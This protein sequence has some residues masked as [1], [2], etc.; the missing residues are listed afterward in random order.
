MIRIILTDICYLLKK[1]WL[2]FIVLVLSIACSFLVFSMMTGVINYE[3]SAAKKSS[4]FHT[5]SIDLTAACLLCT[6]MYLAQRRTDLPPVDRR[7]ANAGRDML[8][9]AIH[10]IHISL[11]PTCS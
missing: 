7:Q 11:L 10:L 2:I 1:Q 5:F 3:I 9:G 6:F 4:A 8:D